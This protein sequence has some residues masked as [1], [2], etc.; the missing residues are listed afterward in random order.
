MKLINKLLNATKM[1]LKLD[2]KFEII[3]SFHLFIFWSKGST[4][5][6]SVCCELLYSVALWHGVQAAL[7]RAFTA[8]RAAPKTC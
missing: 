2:L 7:Y 4:W 6:L 3:F 1:E 5:S 8:R